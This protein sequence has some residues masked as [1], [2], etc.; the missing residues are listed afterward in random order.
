MR[1]IFLSFSTLLVEKKTRFFKRQREFENG[2][3]TRSLS[4]TTTLH[5]RFQLFVYKSSLFLYIYLSSRF[6]DKTSS[7]QDVSTSDKI[8][9]KSPLSSLLV[10]RADF[11]SSVS[12][13]IRAPKVETSLFTRKVVKEH[14]FSGMTTSSVGCLNNETH[15]AHA[16]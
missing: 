5:H 4:S 12:W 2:K 1:F 13:T 14:L 8:S 7:N 16:L 9:L 3:K 6:E 10:F 11:L 15:S